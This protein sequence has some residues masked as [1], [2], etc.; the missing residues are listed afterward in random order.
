MCK[1]TALSIF[2]YFN[3]VQDGVTVSDSLD[4][5]D[6]FCS[7]LGY[8]IQTDPYQWSAKFKS[9]LSCRKWNIS[10][11]PLHWLPFPK[12]L[13]LFSGKNAQINSHDYS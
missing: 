7:A 5:S 13:K 12:L 6:P 1:A 9:Y 10:L 11:K 4:K 3:M 8:S 2:E